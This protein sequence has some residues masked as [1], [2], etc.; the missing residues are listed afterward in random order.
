MPIHFTKAAFL[1]SVNALHQ[2]PNDEGLEVAFVGYSN[3]GKSSVLNCLTKNKRLA[4]VSK[5]PGRTQFINL[6]AIDAKH[7]IADLPGYG[8]AKVPLTMKEKWL[9]L[10]NAYLKTRKSLCGLVLIMDIRN[11]LKELDLT[12]IDWCTAFEVPLH[13]VLNKS[14]KLSK[15]ANQIAIRQVEKSLEHTP[16]VSTQ[17]FS[18]LK[19]IGIKEL[20]NILNQWFLS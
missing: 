15:S 2:L 12:L 10:I 20:Q 16:L 8:F 6:F 5:T 1:L 7:R 11:P 9:T 4:R 18:A 19:K 14:D 17:L 3:V 13:I